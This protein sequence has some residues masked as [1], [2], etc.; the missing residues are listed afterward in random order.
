MRV[1]EIRSFLFT[2]ALAAACLLP[3]AAIADVPEWRMSLDLDPAAGEIA[4]ELELDLPAGTH[5]FRLLDALELR[6]AHAGDT[7]LGVKRVAPGR[8]R[9][10][11]PADSGI[12]LSWS[13][14]LPDGDPMRSRLFLTADGGFL[15]EGTDWYPRFEQESFALRLEARVPKGQRFVATGSLRGEPESGDEHYSAVHEHPRTD[16]VVLV[17]GPWTERSL[18]T[19]GVQV[20]TL[21]RDDLDAAHA[22][23][24]LEHSAEYLRMFSERA[25]PYPYDSFTIAASPMPVGYAFPG[26]TL[27]GERVIPLPFIPQTSLAHELMHS[28]WGTGVRVDYASG[29]WSE[30][31]TTYMADYHLDELRGEGGSTR[32]RWLLDLAWLPAEEDR[33]LQTFQS[34]NQGAN[35][36]VGYN[37][38]ALL[39]HMLRERIGDEAFDAGT[40]KIADR[41]MFDVAGWEDLIRAFSDAAGRE[42]DSFFAPWLERSGLPELAL[43]SVR[44][45]KNGSGWM[46]SGD[47]EQAQEAAPWPLHVPVVVETNAGQQRHVVEL[48]TH[49]TRFQITLDARAQAVTADPD[50]EVL[51]RLPDPP[52][53]L[54]TASLN[55][56]TRLIATQDGLAPFARAILE[57][58]PEMADAFDPQQP[59]LVMGSTEDV[60]RWLDATDAP[61]A[62]D[63]LARRGHARMWTLPGT[64]TAVV[65]SSDAEGLRNL[66]GA[67]RHHGH[68]SYLV[69][70]ADGRTTEFGVW[71]SE[72]NPLRIA[73]D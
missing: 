62:P 72:T 48:D 12:T 5:E 63:D 38:G 53:I 27:L 50:F 15:P 66:V 69:Q 21:F 17:T 61:K 42:L 4:G 60:I 73:L 58:P 40:R 8:Y 41:H 25:G 34:G 31:L 3:T 55:P 49:R 65:S 23:T 36:I 6:A 33:P 16:A 19:N 71:E 32:H 64:R 30:A 54:R 2:V 22:Q 24:Y 28:W 13:G 70:D 7:E 14:K 9:I 57:H 39:F 35:R 52:P 59:L 43:H 47:L 67:L 10:E 46:L 18:E 29:N 68:R 51:R 20:R 56:N 26:F 1:S 45:E 37:R 11:L 44:Q